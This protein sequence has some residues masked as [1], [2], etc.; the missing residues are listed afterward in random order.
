MKISS[1]E[2]IIIVILIILL[3]VF[4][5][6]IYRKTQCDNMNEN[7]QSTRTLQQ[8]DI[9]I[10]ASF[11]AQKMTKLMNNIVFSECV[12]LQDFK[13]SVDCIIFYKDYYDQIIKNNALDMY[14]YMIRLRRGSF[15]YDPI[16]D[17]QDKF[18]F[19]VYI[20]RA[21]STALSSTMATLITQTNKDGDLNNFNNSF[22][23]LFFANLMSKLMYEIRMFIETPTHIKIKKA[24]EYMDT[25]KP[26]NSIESSSSGPNG[27]N[28]LNDS[29]DSNNININNI[30]GVNENDTEENN[31]SVSSLYTIDLDEKNS[32]GTKHI[33]CNK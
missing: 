15:E 1:S 14:D 8:G 32:D 24:T 30:D 12:K 6:W 28:G 25:S 18:I 7:F 27:L 17:K 31:M 20:S 10:I 26:F 11:G 29:N 9:N 16:D 33:Y 4:T 22:I 3:I 2:K 5:C 23:S 21:F 19:V 13:K